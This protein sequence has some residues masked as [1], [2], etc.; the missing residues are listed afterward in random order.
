[1]EIRSELERRVQRLREVGSWEDSGGFQLPVRPFCVGSD[2]HDL[3]DPPKS[4]RLEEVE[5]GVRFHARL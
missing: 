5:K 1:M 3:R 2:R 4:G